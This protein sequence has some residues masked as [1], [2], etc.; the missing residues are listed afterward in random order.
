MRGVS[1]SK[2]M[3]QGLEV[4]LLRKTV[5]HLR[6]K[7]YPP[8][9]RVRVSVPHFVSD[10]EVRAAVLA[11]LSWIK[12]KQDHFLAHPPTPV[13]EM[14]TGESLFFWGKRHSLEVVER[15]GRHE[16]TIQDGEKLQLSVHGATT[17]ENRLRVVNEWYRSELKQRIPP[18]LSRW[19]PVLGVE[20]REWGVKNMQTRWGSCNI[21]KKR[22]W[23]NLQ[24]AKKPLQCLEYVLVHELLHLLERYHNVRFYNLLDHFLPSWQQS[25]D[26]LN[27]RSER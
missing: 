23:L 1:Q 16:I 24:L 15:Q 13:L 18:L 25:R 8:D 7:V 19:Q 21:C 14:V 11:R 6:L 26:L 5:K 27:S 20:S 2:M 9:G 17:T 3:V 4:E 10:E 12:K 22:I